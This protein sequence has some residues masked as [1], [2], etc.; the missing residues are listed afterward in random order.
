MMSCNDT[1]W[2]RGLLVLFCTLVL[3]AALVLLVLGTA[4]HAGVLHDVAAMLLL[5]FALLGATVAALIAYGLFRRWCEMRGAG[6]KGTG[7]REG[8][9][10]SKVTLPRAIRKKP[11]PMIY[12][13]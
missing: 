1:R 5:A 6:P 12:S 11:D 7:T 8:S 13:Q 3:L 2:R 4:S 10:P 9:G